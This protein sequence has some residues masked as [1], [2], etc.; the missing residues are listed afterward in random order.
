MSKGG[1]QIPRWRRDGKELFYASASNPQIMVVD[2]QLSPSFQ[3]G[4]PRLLFTVP[5]GPVAFDVTADGQKFAKFAVASASTSTPTP[6][7]VVLNWEAGL[8]K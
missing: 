8:R 7:T 5:A 2:V 4:I 3:A 1:G 6:I